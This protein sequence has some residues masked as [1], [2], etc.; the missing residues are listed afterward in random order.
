MLSKLELDV[1]ALAVALGSSPII[2]EQGIWDPLRTTLTGDSYV[3]VDDAC[4]L[5]IQELRVLRPFSSLIIRGDY[6]TL[7]YLQFS[8]NYYHHYNGQTQQVRSGSLSLTAAAA[9]TTEI[10]QLRPASSTRATRAVAI[11]IAR[12]HLV[13]TF[14]LRPDLWRDEYRDAFFNTETSALSIATPLTPEMWMI[15]DAMIDCQFDAP[16]RNIYLR[17]KATE[18]LALSVVQFNNFDLPGGTTRLAPVA[19]D[20]RLIDIAA[21]I[22]RRELSNPPSIDALS[23]RIGINR[24]KLTSGF[25]SAF[26]MTPAEYSRRLRLERAERR[27]SE[28]LDV[29]RVAAE[30]GYDS[31]AAFGRAFRQHFGR[32]PSEIRSAATNPLE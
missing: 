4:V 20:Q 11:H 24:N 18:L 16:V 9:S 28:G 15:I 13:G 7:Q 3:R 32:A 17:A 2:C 31:A 14:G 26:G 1:R 25:H 8:G 6:I 30:V 21:L 22:Y 23:R 29:R 10:R 19:R 5:C 12:D 27:L